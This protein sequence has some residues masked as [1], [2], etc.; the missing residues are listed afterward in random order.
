MPGADMS[1]WVSP[2]EI[3]RLI[4]FLCSDDGSAISGN[5]FRVSGGT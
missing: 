4:L 1:S 3:A 2:Q 5:V